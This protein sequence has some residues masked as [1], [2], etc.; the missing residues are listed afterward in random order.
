MMAV[1]DG[2]PRPLT[3]KILERPRFLRRL[4]RLIGDPQRAYLTCYNSTGL[5]RSLALALDLPLNGLDPDHLNH[6][7]KSGNRR[8]FAE[9]G[10]SFPAG[11]EDLYSED[12]IIDALID[13]GRQCPATQHVVVKLNEGFGGEGNG[14]FAFPAARDD[15]SAVRRALHDLRWTS[16][17]ET[18][19]SFLRKFSTMGGIVE[20]FVVADEIRSPSVQMRITPDG[21]PVPV[22]SHEQV[23]GGATG[24]SYLGCR[25]PAD[26]AYRHLL[27][28]EAQKIGKVLA[29][30]GVLAR[31]A[32]DFMVGRDAAGN[33]QPQAIEIN[34]R[35][36]GTTPPYMALQFLTGGHLDSESG[37][38][39]AP[40][41]K[42]KYYAATDNLKSPAYRGLLPEDLFEIVARRRLG[43]RHS[44]GTGT[45]FHMIGALSQYGKI[46]MTCIADSPADAQELFEQTTRAL[47]VEIDGDSHGVQAP[48][49]D[50]NFQME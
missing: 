7:S 35:M 21:N 3:E 41:G 45:L 44:E 18:I 46:G 29:A 9:A 2:S 24:Q 36:G 11:R 25:F 6:A 28:E 1:H 19:D 23:L 15:C 37:L 40:D 50:R 14:V 32:I 49:L 10:V 43:Y 31:F 39:L 20:E 26:D 17:T 34:L 4:R 27:L 5:E 30:K 47:D 42:A 48:L 22:S 13:L 33:W 16:G 12:D 38:F 8:I